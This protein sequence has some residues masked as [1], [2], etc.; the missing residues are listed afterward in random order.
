[1]RLLHLAEDVVLLVAA[2][3]VIAVLCAALYVVGAP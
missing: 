1:M 2:F 3:S